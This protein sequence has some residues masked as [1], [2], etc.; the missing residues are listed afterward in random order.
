MNKVKLKLILIQMILNSIVFNSSYVVLCPTTIRPGLGFDVSVHILKSTGDV[1]VTLELM[2][3]SSKTSVTSA[4]S[5]IP[6]GQ[7]YTHVYTTIT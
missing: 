1:T 6:E 5:T 4:V 7:H 2:K 3:T